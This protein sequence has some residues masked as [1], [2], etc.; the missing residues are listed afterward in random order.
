MSMH[1]S[2]L[3]GQELL[4]PVPEITKRGAMDTDHDGI[5][6]SCIWRHVETSHFIDEAFRIS[7]Q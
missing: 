3:H 6:F 1:Q 7:L 4:L 2:Y 5:I